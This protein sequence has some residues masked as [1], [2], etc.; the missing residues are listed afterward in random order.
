MGQS[1]PAHY[2]PQGNHSTLMF[3]FVFQARF[4]LT[5]LF[6]RWVGGMDSFMDASLET[7]RNIYHLILRHKFWKIGTYWDI[8]ITNYLLYL[9]ISVDYTISSARIKFRWRWFHQE[10]AE[11][12][13]RCDIWAPTDLWGWLTIQDKRY[14]R[15]LLFKS[16]IPP[17]TSQV[18]FHN[19]S[20]M[21]T[22]SFEVSLQKQDGNLGM[23]FSLWTRKTHRIPRFWIHPGYRDP[24]HKSPVAKYVND[25]NEPLRIPSRMVQVVNNKWLG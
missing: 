7:K 22:E 9:L 2:V 8:L 23:L 1:V 24:P 5:K 25:Q 19:Y 11:R 21:K 12:T 6:N 16:S 14:V 18:F 20:K 13:K 4:L 3:A 10:L 15:R 17:N